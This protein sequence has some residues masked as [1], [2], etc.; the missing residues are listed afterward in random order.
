MKSVD[1]IAAPVVP[2]VSRSNSPRKMK[3]ATNACLRSA[4][5]DGGNRVDIL[6]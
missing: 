5:F 1:D 2:V 4:A 6:Y 3:V